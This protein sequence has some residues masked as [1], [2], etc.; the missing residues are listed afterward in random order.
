MSVS[1][2]IVECVMCARKRLLAVSGSLQVFLNSLI[3][4]AKEFILLPTLPIDGENYRNKLCLDSLLML[5]V[6]R[7]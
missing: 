4:V 7:E 2:G 6:W 1:E 5:S 3:T